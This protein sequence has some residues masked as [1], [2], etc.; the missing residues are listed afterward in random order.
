MDVLSGIIDAAKARVM[1]EEVREYR[2]E[3]RE[4]CPAAPAISITSP[5]GHAI[6]ASRATT[7]RRGV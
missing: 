3:F 7:D 1:F 2:G 4:F 5:P 6:S